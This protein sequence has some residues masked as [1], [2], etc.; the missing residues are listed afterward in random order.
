MWPL[1]RPP[2]GTCLEPLRKNLNL[3]VRR[4]KENDRFYKGL[5]GG[6]T[7]ARTWDPMIKSY[8]LYQLSY[9]PGSWSGKPSQEGVV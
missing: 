5:N 3:V 1:R 9:A 8:L 7:R 2:F 4:S 6:R